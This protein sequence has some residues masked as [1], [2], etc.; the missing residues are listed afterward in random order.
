MAISREFYSTGS[1]ER[2]WEQLTRAAQADASGVSG[3]W[4]QLAMAHRVKRAAPLLESQHVEQAAAVELIRSQMAE[5]D[6][7]LVKRSRD[8]KLIAERDALSRKFTQESTALQQIEQALRFIANVKEP[9][10]PEWLL[11]WLKST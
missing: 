10:A 11:E 3:F 4:Y 8:T 6:E 5:H 1:G 9:T 7:Q 2:Y